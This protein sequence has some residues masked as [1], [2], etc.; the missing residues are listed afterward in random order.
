MLACSVP[1]KGRRSC[2]AVSRAEPR[3]SVAQRVPASNPCAPG[4]RCTFFTF[5][6]LPEVGRP[7]PPRTP[8]SS[9][10][11][12]IWVRIRTRVPDTSTEGTWFPGSREGLL[13]CFSAAVDGKGVGPETNQLKGKKVLAPTPH[14]LLELLSPAILSSL[15]VQS[16]QF[17]TIYTTT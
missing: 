14:T 3:A 11:R 7:E 12:R 13:F 8:L 15:C 4:S 1:R 6:L 9:S 17:P 5:L 2:L 16:A 10:Q